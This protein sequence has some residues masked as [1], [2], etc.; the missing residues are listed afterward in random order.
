MAAGGKCVALENGKQADPQVATHRNDCGAHGKEG[1]DGSSPSEGSKRPAN[2]D[3]ALSVLYR[4]KEGAS[5]AGE[6]S[7][8]CR[9]LAS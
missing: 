2:R 1:I 5:G 3:F 7:L 8:V 4:G 9:T 6:K